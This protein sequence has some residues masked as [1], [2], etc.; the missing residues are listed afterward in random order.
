MRWLAHLYCAHS[1]ANLK[2]YCAHIWPKG[3]TA[4]SDIVL[5]VVFGGV[6]LGF[7]YVLISLGL[8]LIFGV[9]DICN[10]AHGDFFTMAMYGAF[11]FSLWPGLDPL[12]SLPL[13]ALI[14]GLFGSV[15]YWLLIRRVL[16]A[17]VMAQIFVTFGLMIFIR[18]LAQALFSANYRSVADPMIQGTIAF[19]GSSLSKPQVVAALGAII[20][21]ILVYLFITETRTGW[22]IQAVSENRRA[23]SLMGI[24][25]QKMFI[26]VWAIGAA[27]VGVAG[28][29]MAQYYYIY[30]E[31]GALFGS[32]SFI[33]VALGG[34]GSITGVFIA[35]IIIGMIEVIGG[36]FLDPAYKYLLVFGLYFVVIVIR[37]QGIMGRS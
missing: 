18:G 6:I 33:T 1:I 32:L 14:L 22:A 34:F 35:G 9:M 10:F 26:L 27:C 30:P 36:F 12:V 17:P 31:V 3:V 25:V 29:L 16:N 4:M 37:P 2:Q 21:T 8:T 23:A 13:V 15:V 28:S 20:A 11:C 19:L 7:I 5:Q 24:P